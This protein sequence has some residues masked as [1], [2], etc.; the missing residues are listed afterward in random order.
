MHGCRDEHMPRKQPGSCCWVCSLDSW[1][2]VQADR[3]VNCLVE[4]QSN[5]QHAHKTSPRW[6]WKDNPGAKSPCCSSDDLSSVPRAYTRCLATICNCLPKGFNLFWSSQTTR[7]THNP[8][9]KKSLVKI[10]RPLMHAFK[11]ILDELLAEHWA[12][13][14]NTLMAMHTKGQD[15]T[16]LFQ[17]SRKTET[18]ER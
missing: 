5:T 7:P 17:R 11:E 10:D 6:R 16:T 9:I 15:L 1:G 14:A 8:T 12:N 3:C 2:S 18:L 13:W 4:C